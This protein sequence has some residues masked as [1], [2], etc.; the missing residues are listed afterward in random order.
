MPP[1]NDQPVRRQLFPVCKCIHCDYECKSE[2]ALGRHVHYAHPETKGIVQL[3]LTGR[4]TILLVD[5]IEEFLKSASPDS[6]VTRTLIAQLQRHDLK[7]QAA[8]RLIATEKV[9][10]IGRL[11]GLASAVDAALQKALI[12]GR[13]LEKMTTTE[14]GVKQL[15]AIQERL[16]AAALFELRFV[17]EVIGLK[18]ESGSGLAERVASIFGSID[19]SKDGTFTVRKTATVKL[20][21]DPAEREELRRVFADM[22]EQKP[23]RRQLQSVQE[24]QG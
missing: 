7:V 10:R 4:D 20:P 6:P 5:A 13:G 12:T 18:D 16:E 23:V 22:T 2:G 11:V 8:T 1:D 15:M 19:V 17:R 21:T 9:L 3:H 24:E 14:K